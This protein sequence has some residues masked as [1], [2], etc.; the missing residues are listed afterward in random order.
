MTS[1]DI[2]NSITPIAQVSSGSSSIKKTPL[3]ETIKATSTFG[4][5]LNDLLGAHSASDPV[6]EEDI[7][8][9]IIGQ[10][11]KDQL[12][13]ATYKDY[14]TALKIAMSE[15]VPGHSLPSTE[16]SAR[17]AVKYLVL[18][19]S[20][21]SVQSRSIRTFARDTAQLDDNRA[22]YDGIGGEGDETIAT[23]SF[24][25][26]EQLISGK[27]SGT[28]ETGSS[29]TPIATPTTPTT[30][31]S[32]TTSSTPSNSITPASASSKG[33]E[34]SYSDFKVSNLD[35]LKNIDISD[36][37]NPIES[38]SKFRVKALSLID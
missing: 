3:N 11:I 22:L 37:I 26:V 35:Q 31:T 14:K 6:S 32:T 38:K 9:A 36:L 16:Y 10:Q 2:K 15:P 17:E 4:D 25:E 20:L 29:P 34:R 21:T 19:D 5:T 27:L 33:L 7:Y 24:S 13:E 1:S 8:A 30:T 18:T 12:G 23:S 28:I